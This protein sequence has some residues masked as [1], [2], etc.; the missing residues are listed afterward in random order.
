MTNEQ[1]PVIEQ[2]AYVKLIKGKKCYEWEI[3]AV[4]DDLKANV[5][6]VSLADEELN[7]LYGTIGGLDGSGKED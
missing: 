6:A 1:T 2:R 5:A 4:G 3:K 7:S